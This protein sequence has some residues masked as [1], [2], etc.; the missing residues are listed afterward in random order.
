MTKHASPRSF[1]LERPCWAIDHDIDARDIR[2]TR[3]WEGWLQVASE[4][5]RDIGARDDGLQSR[6]VA[7]VYHRTGDLRY[8][9]GPALEY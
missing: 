6:V 8:A 2:D 9:V 5:P 3:A 4:Y 1:G 7:H